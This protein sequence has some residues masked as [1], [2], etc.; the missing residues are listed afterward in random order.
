MYK[1]LK[2]SEDTRQLKNIVKFGAFSLLP[3]DS[4]MYLKLHGVQYC[5][6]DA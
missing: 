5:T 2:C 6:E 4:F 1:E 3:N